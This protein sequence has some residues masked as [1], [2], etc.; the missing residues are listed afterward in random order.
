MNIGTC[1]HIIDDEWYEDTRSSY[2]LIDKESG[3]VNWATTCNECWKA[4]M[5]SGLVTDSPEVDYVEFEP[6]LPDVVFD[7]DGNKTVLTKDDEDGDLPNVNHKISYRIVT[8]R[9]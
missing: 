4:N 7:A 8:D 3:T 1:G 5:E 9:N 6:E 2:Y